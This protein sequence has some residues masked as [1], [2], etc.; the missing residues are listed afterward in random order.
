[1]YDPAL[2]RRKNGSFR[3]LYMDFR[4]FWYRII[5]RRKDTQEASTRPKGA[6]APAAHP[7]T[8]PRGGAGFTTGVTKLDDQHHEIREAILGFQ[9]ELGRGMAPET[10]LPA[11]DALLQRMNDHF[12]YEESYLEH[13]KFP[14]LAHHKEEHDRFRTEVSQLRERLADGDQGVSLDLS[15]F[16]FNW[17]R[18]HTLEEDATFAKAKRKP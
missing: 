11:L 18:R 1:M 6:A 15:S 7:Q 9:K 14:D 10:H 17:F 2:D 3:I 13:I 5:L 12:R 4:S 16:L 8:Q